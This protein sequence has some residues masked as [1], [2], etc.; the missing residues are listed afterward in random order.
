MESGI[1]E[2]LV[3]GRIYGPTSPENSWPEIEASVIRDLLRGV[4]PDIRP[5]P[6]G[7]RLRHVRIIGR[8]DLDRVKTDVALEIDEC[9]LH[10]GITAQQ[11]QLSALVVRNIE[12]NRV[13]ATE[14]IID[15]QDATT[16]VVNL[17]GTKL[18]NFNG[19]VLSAERLRVDIGMFLGGGFTATGKGAGGVV[20]LLGAA[21]AGQLS[22]QGAQLINST[23]PA[24]SAGNMTVGHDFFL[25]HL[26]IGA[27]QK[28]ETDFP[29]ARGEVI[30]TNAAVQGRFVT[31]LKGLTI[32][33]DVPGSWDVTGF[34]FRSIAGVSPDEWLAF[35]RH[36]T[37]EYSP[38]PYQQL[39]A[40]SRREG[41]ED[42]VRKALIAQHDDL[43]KRSKRDSG[44]LT[45]RQRVNKCL[46]KWTVGYGYRPW[47][48]LVWLLIFLGITTGIT[49]LMQWQDA[50]NLIDP[51]TSEILG[52][53]SPLDLWTLVLDAVPLV[54]GFET[55]CKPV[56]WQKG[57]F[58]FALSMKL[59]AWGLLTLFIAG[60]TNIIRKP[61]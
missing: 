45:Q 16:Q 49:Y 12:I 60:F 25:D 14:P 41:H 7:L 20:R 39:A 8:L 57:Y 37:K 28:S 27:G 46:L 44:L 40:V 17:S 35:L 10:D 9:T 58:L 32:R 48:A 34:T 61:A 55:N 23:G 59:S 11:A 3:A 31:S 21:V 51:D 56:K 1:T 26:N 52:N 53:C 29:P 6:R 4:D 33:K 42:V 5:D 22:F 38:H 54:E 50:L 47:G 30:L 2:A 15:L 36:G 18:T 13:S 43:R 24:L 19:P